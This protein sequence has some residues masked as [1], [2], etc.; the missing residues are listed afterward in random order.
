MR[1]FVKIIPLRAG[2]A[3]PVGAPRMLACP[4]SVEPDTILSFLIQKLGEVVEAIWT[5]TERHERID[6][7][8]VFPDTSATEARDAVELACVPFIEIADGSLQPMFEAQADQRQE[9]GELAASQGLDYRVIEQAHRAYD[10]AT[11][12]DA[13]TGRRDGQL[14]VFTCAGPGDG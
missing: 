5:F 10:P 14:A 12:H 4:P 11:G 3:E 8:W 6:I 13:S 2:T 9:F 1:L 7:G